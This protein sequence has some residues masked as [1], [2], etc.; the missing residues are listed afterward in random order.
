MTTRKKLEAMLIERGMS[1]GQATKVMDLSIPSLNKLGDN[2][3]IT[4]DRPSDE[5]PTLIYHIWFAT[6]K[7][8]ALKW[9]DENVPQAW[10]REMFV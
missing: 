9:I 6:V 4:F 1:E 3:K 10:F 8:I 2:Y 7:P 5:Y